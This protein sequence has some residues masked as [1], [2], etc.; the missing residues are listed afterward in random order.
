MGSPDESDETFRFTIARHTSEDEAAGLPDAERLLQ[1]RAP[2]LDLFHPWSLT[3]EEAIE[4][5]KRTEAAA[6]RVDKRIPLGRLGRPEDMANM[7]LA[8]LSDRFSGYVTGSTVA[9][10]GGLALFNWIPL[11]TG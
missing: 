8:L 10:D 1:G 5:A 6:L 9:V 2:D 3:V 4:L 11:P 7:A